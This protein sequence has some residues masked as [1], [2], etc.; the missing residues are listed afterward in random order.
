MI[1][2]AVLQGDCLEILKTLPAQSADCCVTS[3]PYFQL[4]DYGIAGQIG[5]EETPEKYIEKLTAVFAEV[6]RVL[7]DGGTLWVNI[8]DT[9]NGSCRNNGAVCENKKWIQRSNTASQA[10]AF[11]KLKGYKA[12]TLLGVPFM[13]ALSMIRDGWLLRQDI[14]WAK[15]NPM[16]ESVTDRFCKSHEYLFLFAKR[17]K[18]YFDG[19]AALELATGYD[20]GHGRE[21]R[22]GYAAKGGE[23]GLAP[24]RHGA[25]IRTYPARLKRDVWTVAGE[26]SG[27]KHYAMFPQ[28][29]ILPCILCGCPQDGIALDPFM[30]GGTTA[31]VAKKHMRKYIGIEIN[32]EYIKIAERRLAEINPLFEGEHDNDY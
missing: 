31:V 32:P 18:Y 11:T 16:P 28:K 24:Q 7:K 20:G 3:P 22:R 19:K 29:L 2:N 1:E 27:E 12:K 13:F 5:L 23:T 4:R 8:G 21:P 15:Q 26:P 30:G 25:S 6:R 17:A 14:I 10:V 9:Y